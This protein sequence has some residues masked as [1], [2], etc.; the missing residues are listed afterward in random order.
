MTYYVEYFADDA[1]GQ[2]IPGL[3]KIDLIDGYSSF[4]DIPKI[5]EAN[6][7]HRNIVITQAT[8]IS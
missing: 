7:G 8:L 1:R 6:K 3:I 4:S 2:R 5:I